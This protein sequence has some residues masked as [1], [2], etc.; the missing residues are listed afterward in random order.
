MLTGDGE[1]TPASAAP[2]AQI[3]FS[4]EVGGH[5]PARLSRHSLLNYKIEAQNSAS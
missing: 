3:L 2:S 1:I 5:L 4:L